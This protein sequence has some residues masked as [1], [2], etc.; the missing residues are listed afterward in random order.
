M[1]SAPVT[2]VELSKAIGQA[3]DLSQNGITHPQSWKG[4]AA[5]RLAAAGVKSE[6]TFQKQTALVSLIADGNTVTFTPH[7]NGGTT[8]NEKGFSPIDECEIKVDQRAS[9]SAGEI[10]LRAFE[11]C[12]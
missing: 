4:L 12:A 1:L 11:R 5:P 6:A 3:L 9:E 8:G 2:S 10:A 7:R